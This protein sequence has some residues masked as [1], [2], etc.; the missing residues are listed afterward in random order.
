MKAIAA[1]LKLLDF[2]WKPKY[3]FL[4]NKNEMVII[5]IKRVKIGNLF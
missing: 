5:I 2:L 1:S 3:V 4:R